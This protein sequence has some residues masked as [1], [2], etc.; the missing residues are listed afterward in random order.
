MWYESAVTPQVNHLE[1]D[2]LHCASCDDF[3][4]FMR[5]FGNIKELDLLTKSGHMGIHI[6]G[7]V[8]LSRI[9]LT[10]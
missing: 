7:E 5:K 1:A 9:V 3:E 6:N 8:I 10:C 4:L 2:T